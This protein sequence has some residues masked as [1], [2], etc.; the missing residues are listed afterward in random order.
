MSFI[1]DELKDTSLI[2]AKFE[3][4]RN[5]SN[6][7]APSQKVD[8]LIENALFEELQQNP[9]RARRLYEQ[10]DQEI[11]PGLVKANIARINFEKR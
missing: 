11:A 10:L 2:R 9:M 5:D 8:M 4:K 7:M 1:Q 3:Q 6:L